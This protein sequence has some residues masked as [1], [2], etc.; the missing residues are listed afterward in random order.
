[1]V[2]SRTNIIEDDMVSLIKDKNE[3]KRYYSNTV[4]EISLDSRFK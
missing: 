2:N 1:M 4:G 3:L